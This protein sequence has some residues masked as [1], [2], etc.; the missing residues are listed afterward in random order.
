MFWRTSSFS[1]IFN[2]QFSIEL[3]ADGLAVVLYQ[4]ALGIIEVE[5]LGGILADEHHIEAAVLQHTIELTLTG[6]KRYG[7]GGIV[8]GDVDGGVLTLLVIVVGAFVLVELELTVRARVYIKMYQ[9]GRLLI[10][11]LH[12]RTE[13]NDSALAHED[14]DLLIRC[15]D[16]EALATFGIFTRIE[17]VPT[18]LG[19]EVNRAITGLVVAYRTCHQGRTEHPLVADIL[20]LLIAIEV[21]HQRAHQGVILEVC[22]TSH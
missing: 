9:L 17:V 22:P 7:A 21:H 16:D 12:L 11:P 20:Y 2:I 15:I 14:G 10:A 19:G 3:N 6:A 5:G 13:G 1:S 18:C 8:V 4:L